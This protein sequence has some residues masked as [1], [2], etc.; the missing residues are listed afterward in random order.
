[1]RSEC[2]GSRSHREIA[3]AFHVFVLVL[4]F[5]VFLIFQFFVVAFVVVVIQLRV[6]VEV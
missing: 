5:V 4:V 3:Q 6:A 2:A 1:V